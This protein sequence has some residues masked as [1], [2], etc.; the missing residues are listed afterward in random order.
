MWRLTNCFSRKSTRLCFC[1]PYYHF[2]DLCRIKKNAQGNLAIDVPLESPW[3]PTFDDVVQFGIRLVQNNAHFDLLYKLAAQAK[4]LRSVMKCCSLDMRCWAELVRS[5]HRLRGLSSWGA[6][7]GSAA[8]AKRWLGKQ[9]AILVDK[10]QLKPGFFSS[11][12]CTVHKLIHKLYK[13]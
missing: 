1:G 10:L 5:V 4:L 2:S 12:L 9:L 8:L 3:I 6:F 13:F 11:V 7:T